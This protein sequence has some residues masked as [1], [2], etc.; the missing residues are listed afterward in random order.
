MSNPF[1]SKQLLSLPPCSR[2]AISFFFLNA[3]SFED[4]PRLFAR[5]KGRDMRI[6]AQLSFVACVYIT[7]G[8]KCCMAAGA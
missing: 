4:D 5:D 2:F 8:Q 3:T 7:V 6:C 1:T